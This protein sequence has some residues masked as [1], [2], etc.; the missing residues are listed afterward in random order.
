MLLICSTGQ[1]SFPSFYT[2]RE[3]TTPP[4]E[5]AKAGWLV[6]HQ[7]VSKCRDGGH[8]N[9]RKSMK[10]SRTTLGVKCGLAV[11]L[12][13]AAQV[14]NI[15]TG[16]PSLPDMDKR[17][18]ITTAIPLTR[19]RQQAAELLQTRIPSVAIDYDPITGAPNWIW[20]NQ[21]FLNSSDAADEVLRPRTFSTA[22]S[23]PNDPY[24]TIK[25]FLDANEALF[26]HGSEVLSNALL[27][28]D[29]ITPH[30]G[31]RTVVW[32]QQLDGIA[33]FGGFL[34]G[35]ITIR[36][37]LVN[38]SSRFLP[39]IGS[40]VA[41]DPT[42][43][44]RLELSPPITA[45]QAVANALS[46][47]AEPTSVVDVAPEF[48]SPSQQGPTNELNFNAAAVRDQAKA[49]LVWV[50]I[51]RSMV[52]LCWSVF[53]IKRSTT[54]GFN[55]LV[56][57][58]TGEVLVR[59]NLTSKYSNASY[60]VFTSDS[61]APLTPGW[62]TPSTTQATPVNPSLVT[63]PFVS[64]NAS[65]N[66]WINDGDNQTVGN[67]IDAYL[68]R[69]PGNVSPTRVQGS[70]WR[71]FDFPP[72]LNQDP[73]R[74]ENASVV[75]LFYWCNWAHDRLYDL[76]FTT[77][78]QGSSKI[79]AYAQ[80]GIDANPPV[81]N[82]SAFTPTG[83]AYGP[84]EI[85]M[86]IFTCPN[87]ARDADL[88][89][90][91]ILHE[92]THGLTDRLVLGLL[93]PRPMQTVGMSEGW[94]DFYA[95]SLLSEPGDNVHASYPFGG[96]ITFYLPPKDAPCP[97]STI[98]NYYYGFRRYPYSTETNYN[99]LTLRDIDTNQISPH[100]G[101][102]LNPDFPFD[103]SQ[104]N[105][106]HHQGEVWCVALWEA[107]AN[108]IDHYGYATGN[109]LIMRIVMDGMRITP[110]G[111][112]FIQ[113][114]D[115]I[116]QA[117]MVDTGGAE[118]DDLWKAFAHR[119]MGYNA[120]ARPSNVTTGVVESV[121]LPPRGT[122]KWVYTMPGGVYSSPALR[123]DGTIYVG[124]VW[125]DNK[126]YAINTNGTLK[127][128]FAGYSGNWSFYSSP[129][130]GPDGTIY[131]GCYD[132]QLYALNPDGSQKWVYDTGGE[133]FSSPA[134]G[135]D[136]T[137]YFGAIDDQKI[138]A[139]K[140]NGTLKWSKTTGNTVYSSP[141]LSP[142]ETVIYVG[143][144]DGKVYALDATT[145]TDKPGW[146]YTTSGSVY[147]S[148]AV[149]SD[150]SIYVG[151]FS[152]SV[153]A[154]NSNGTA[155]W[156]YNTGGA[157]Y[158]SPS[159]GP[160]GTIYVGSYNNKIYGLDPN[161]GAVKTGWPYTTGSYVLS[162]PA[163]AA[164]GTVYI[165]STDGKVYALNPDGT[166]YG[167]SWPFYTSGDV[168]SSPT[169]GPDGT[170]YVGSGV[171]KLYALSGLSGLAKSSWPM[172]RQN[173]LHTGNISTNA[174]YPS[175]SITSPI[176]DFTTQ[177][178]WKERGYGSNGYYI[179]GDSY[180]YPTYIPGITLFGASTY[181]WSNAPTDIRALER[182]GVG[183]IAAC[184]YNSSSF[185]IVVPQTD[186]LQHL[187]SLYFLDWDSNARVQT[188][189]IRN[190]LSGQS[191]STATL[192]NFTNGQYYTWGVNGSVTIH[193]TRTGGANA[194]LSGIFFGP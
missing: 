15:S 67:N 31:M 182:G 90:E 144:M 145:G 66:G 155:R 125:P 147:S 87:V 95:L 32:Q 96:Y 47:A 56:D 61:P 181:V 70:S 154:L 138:Y 133:I 103:S 161:T 190:C 26:E 173:R 166:P 60:K 55:S 141:A 77:G 174:W 102:P 16:A 74:Y 9:E 4:D 126:L 34:K 19:Q 10:M 97:S 85:D 43:R 93:G 179:V 68:N 82:N 114:R 14:G 193:T 122:Q 121:T 37:E 44:S 124:T 140:P 73:S 101:V 62:T 157:V 128:T 58:S 135:S 134:I 76:G 111:P 88:D 25:N 191:L 78:Y 186:G 153:Y 110:Q 160:D 21:R 22:S 94:S 64:Q 51:N 171:G 165:G 6:A 180:S 36:G 48:D 169:I 158:S 142:D 116:L 105:E 98:P 163:V 113:A 194:V 168:S 109:D 17:T 184:W 164:D 8:V 39:N 41:L 112:D 117:D 54:E 50:P 162:S 108:V 123:P 49:S 53:F 131:V 23:A 183:R 7:Q 38:I 172:F 187:I 3:T 100:S 29:Y 75:S 81:I 139:L 177:G 69:N 91:V 185:D 79:T 151:S 80:Y 42:S 152:G 59:Q 143:S 189:D 129:A 5:E 156:A 46:D 86:M 11:I 167:G 104:A 192:A 137:I 52:R 72:D 65:P 170:V 89:A 146:P 84:G 130:L 33:L 27:I 18:E 149:A 12:W 178:N 99:P 20:S 132:T 118:I 150:G 127:W 119:G 120:S 28:Q 2:S 40:A 35:H 148:P 175:V 83:G 92:Y 107:R 71:V 136:G 115:A 106:V 13:S 24:H 63:R 176:R 57:A 30:N 45:Q 188:V 159:I 1:S